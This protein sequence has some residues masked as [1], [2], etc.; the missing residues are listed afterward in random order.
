MG[1]WT[2]KTKRNAKIK[3]KITWWQRELKRSKEVLAV[4]KSNPRYTTR[5]RDGGGI[6]TQESRI[7]SIE[8][9]IED[10]KKKLKSKV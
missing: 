5:H 3:K 6:E 7:K 1:K 8:K 10:L 9:V 4:D 2:A